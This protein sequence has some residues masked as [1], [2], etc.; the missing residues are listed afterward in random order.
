M[1]VENG[2]FWSEIGSGFGKAGST[3]LPI[4][5]RSISPPPP[6]FL[7]HDKLFKIQ[8]NHYPADV[9]VE[10]DHLEHFTLKHVK[11]WLKAVSG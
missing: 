8:A 5:P 11:A 6:G 4:I 1:G 10:M 2:I 9:T 7:V 3:H